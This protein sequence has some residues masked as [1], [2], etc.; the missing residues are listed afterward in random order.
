M[1]PISDVPCRPRGHHLA[2][3]RTDGQ[4]AGSTPC[5]APRAFTRATETVLATH[6][7]VTPRKRS[8]R[9]SSY[10]ERPGYPNRRCHERYLFGRRFMASRTVLTSEPPLVC[11]STFVR[12]APRPAPP[13]IELPC[14]SPARVTRDASDRLLP[15][16]VLRTSTRASLVLGASDACAPARSRRSPASRSGR[17]ASAGRTLSPNWSRPGGRCLPL[18]TRA[19]RASDNPC[20]LPHGARTARA[21]CASV[22]AAKIARIAFA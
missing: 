3:S 11:V 15:S 16:H 20:R 18:V 5:D 8:G 4:L 1:E 7:A 10:R 19:N 13:A 17:F 2:G 12:R 14:G 22:K 21:A 6:L 9:L